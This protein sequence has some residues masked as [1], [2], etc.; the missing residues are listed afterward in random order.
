M[1]RRCSY[2]FRALSPWKSNVSF[3]AANRL[4]ELLAKSRAPGSTR[5][6]D[7]LIH[8]SS[9]CSNISPTGSTSWGASGGPSMRGR[10]TTGGSGGLATGFSFLLNCSACAAAGFKRLLIRV[11]RSSPRS[12]EAK[13]TSRTKLRHSFEVDSQCGGPKRVQHSLPFMITDPQALAA[14]V[15]ASSAFPPSEDWA[16]LSHSS[17]ALLLLVVQAVCCAVP[18]LFP[19]AV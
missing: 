2:W 17:S 12:T 16:A 5:R 18:P 13:T 14:S 19:A 8:I 1:E 3:K 9:S 11:T 15:A 6:Q 4:A 7:D 10:V